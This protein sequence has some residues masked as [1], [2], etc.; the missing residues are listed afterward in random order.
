MGR[1]HGNPERD[2]ELGGGGGASVSAGRLGRPNVHSSDGGHLQAARID[3]ANTAV[4]FIVDD[5]AAGAV[6]SAGVA[7]QE[8]AGSGTAVTHGAVA[9]NGG[10]VAHGV[11][12][13]DAKVIVVR[14]EDIAGRVHGEIHF[15]SVLGI[16]Q[17]RRGW[18][19]VSRKTEREATCADSAQVPGD[20]ADD[21]IGRAHPENGG[22]SAVGNQQISGQ[23]KS[24]AGGEKE[25]SLGSGGS[26]GRWKRCPAARVCGDCLRGRIHQPHSAI[27]AVGD[28]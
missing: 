1:V 18:S 15:D 26:G 4:G 7:K 14:N 28:V 5:Q 8:G 17:S 25:L 12:L 24:Q 21:L 20:D 10:D 6:Q 3:S 22:D 9:G 16:E 2:K 19:A 11:D 27:I 23:I 13:A